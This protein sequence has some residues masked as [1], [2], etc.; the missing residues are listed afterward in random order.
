MEVPLTR[1]D[2]E[3]LC[4]CLDALLE[5]MEAGGVSPAA[6]LEP[7]S[8]IND[9]WET[10]K[11]RRPNAGGVRVLGAEPR[12]DPAIVRCAAAARGGGAMR[13]HARERRRHRD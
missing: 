8:A 5:A 12:A 7:W 10:W 11:T 3:V 4:F 9:A 13:A 6:A 2:V 1:A